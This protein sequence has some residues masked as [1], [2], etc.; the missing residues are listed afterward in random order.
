MNA[1]E[2]GGCGGD[3]GICTTRGGGRSLETGHAKLSRFKVG[4]AAGPSYATPAVLQN[5]SA[6]TFDQ[7]GHTCVGGRGEAS[8]E[9]YPRAEE[10]QINERKKKKNNVLQ[11]LPI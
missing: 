7:Y 1:G 4:R 9:I 5:G 3:L 10:G 8:N 11:F 6:E 2:E